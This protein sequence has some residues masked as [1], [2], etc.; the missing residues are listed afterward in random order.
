MVTQDYRQA[1]ESIRKLVWL[2]LRYDLLRT[3]PAPQG[4]GQRGRYPPLPAASTPRGPFQLD[5]TEDE[6]MNKKKPQMGPFGDTLVDFLQV[7]AE[8]YGSRDA[9]LFKPGFRYHRWSY[10]DVW[11]S[12]GRVATLL[13]ERGVKK[14]DR[15]IIWAPNSPHWVLALFG[16]IRAGAVAVPLDL[17][18]ADDFAE[19]VA[20]RTRPASAFV[21]R[22]TPAAHEVLWR[23]GGLLRGHGAP[24]PRS[25]AATSGGACGRRP[26]RGRVH[27]RHHRQPQ[28]R[29]ADPWK[30]DREYPLRRPLLPGRP[31]RPPPLR[32]P[33]QS[34]VRADGRVIRGDA[35]G[36]QHHLPHEQAAHRPVEDDAR[37]QG[38]SDAPGPTGAGASHGRHRKGGAQ[39]G[40]GGALEQA[41]RPGRAAALRREAQALRVGAQDGSA[42]TSS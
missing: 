20:A 39:A 4:R 1:K 31:V 15:V 37:A 29:Y 35:V 14:G 2:R 8:S 10:R 5:R 18:C 26:R 33:A 7:A 21:S 12:A 23:P 19:N 3:L 28:G 30:P 11:E 17:N 27:V 22:M 42:A 34:H 38:D 6:A 32:A 25:A 9:L 36:R 41:A 16:T 24:R 40:Q 13:Q